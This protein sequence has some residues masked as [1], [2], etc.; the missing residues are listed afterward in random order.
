M[1]PVGRKCTRCARPS[2]KPYRRLSFADAN[3]TFIKVLTKNF[4]IQLDTASSSN[5]PPDLG[6]IYE[7]AVPRFTTDELIDLNIELKAK[8]HKVGFFKRFLI[9][10]KTLFSG[11]YDVVIA[12]EA[13]SRITHKKTFLKIAL[14][15][16]ELPKNEDTCEE[17]M[18]LLA[19]LRTDLPS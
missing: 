10:L 4:H 8:K 5:F 15:Y 17:N 16:I 13:F 2:L 6:R 11:N 9:R 12:K 1:S 14:S 3:Q 19:E 7:N 18:K